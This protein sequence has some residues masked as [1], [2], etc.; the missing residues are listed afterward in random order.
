M[1]PQ[2]LVSTNRKFITF[3]GLLCFHKVSFPRIAT[4]QPFWLV[5]ILQYPA[6]VLFDRREINPL[7][8]S[9]KTLHLMPQVGLITLMHF[10]PRIL[11]SESSL[12]DGIY[13]VAK[14]CATLYKRVNEINE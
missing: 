9:L 10:Q 6:S 13:L 8:K 14:I 5:E 11:K 7:T 1:F 2:N 3:S 12:K 4:S